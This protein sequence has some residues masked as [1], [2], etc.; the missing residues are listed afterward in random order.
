MRGRVDFLGGA[1]ARLREATGRTRFRR[2][3]GI[4]R[5]EAYLSGSGERRNRCVVYCR[6]TAA[7]QKMLRT[8]GTTSG[9]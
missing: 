1:S 9:Q 8:E 3:N 4:T 7:A 2:E 5:C 6:S